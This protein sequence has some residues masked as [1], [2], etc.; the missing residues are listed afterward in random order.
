MV[1]DLVMIVSLWFTKEGTPAK[2]CLEA[3]MD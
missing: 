3:L 1:D 2:A